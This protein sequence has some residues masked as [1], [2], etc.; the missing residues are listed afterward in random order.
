MPDQMSMV[1]LDIQVYKVLHP[2]L[3]QLFISRMC[4][5]L[6]TPMRTPIYAEGVGKTYDLAP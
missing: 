1:G 4:S 2:E 5:Y 3:E 6:T